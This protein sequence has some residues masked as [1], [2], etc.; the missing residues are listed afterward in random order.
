MF[1]VYLQPRPELAVIVDSPD[2]LVD[3]FTSARSYVRSLREIEYRDMIRG[4]F[5]GQDK[6]MLDLHDK[7]YDREGDAST[8]T[9][10]TNDI[11]VANSD[12]TDVVYLARTND[13]SIDIPSPLIERIQ[14]RGSWYSIGT[15][16]MHSK[17]P[18][19]VLNELV[20]E[21]G[22]MPGFEYINRMAIRHPAL[23]VN[24][25]KFLMESDR[26]AVDE[27]I[28]MRYRKDLDE[29]YKQLSI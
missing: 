10:L 9:S 20:V 23:A 27:Q 14:A 4:Y 1:V 15:L 18:S 11:I 7:T 5:S 25:A 2:N 8:L 26:L 22:Q 29:R 16:A 3:S 28:N 13:V 17:L 24:T 6:S 21:Y 19:G 12:I